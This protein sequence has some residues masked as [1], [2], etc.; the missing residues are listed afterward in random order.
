MTV[1]QNLGF[2]DS[3]EAFDIASEVMARLLI[4]NGKPVQTTHKEKLAVLFLSASNPFSLLIPTL[5][6]KKTMGGAMRK[7]ASK[8]T[9]EEMLL[10]AGS[11]LQ[12]IS[13]KK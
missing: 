13:P 2:K 6:K 4:N 8:I 5:A 11:I 10:I 1:I 12:Q 3:K 7:L 9:D